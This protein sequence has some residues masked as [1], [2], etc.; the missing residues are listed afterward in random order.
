MQ[1]SRPP[2]TISDIALSTPRG[3]VVVPLDRI[4]ACTAAGKESILHVV[5]ENGT[6][7][8]YI[9]LH[10]LKE[11]ETLCRSNNAFLR[12]HWSSLINLKHCTGWREE[13]CGIQAIMRHGKEFA[14]S[15]RKKAAFLDGFTRLYPSSDAVIR[16]KK[17]KP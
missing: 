7:S 14:V 13:G 17:S 2:D 11:V 8:E 6:A 12:C 5:A 3:V 9:I 15:K 4:I 1:S 16:R 10:L